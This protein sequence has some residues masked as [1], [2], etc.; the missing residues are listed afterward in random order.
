[1]MK[2]Q[3][4]GFGERDARF[5]TGLDPRPASITNAEASSADDPATDRRSAPSIGRRAAQAFRDVAEIV[6]GERWMRR[7]FPRYPKRPP[8]FFNELGQPHYHGHRER[9]RRRFLATWPDGLP[10]YELLELVLFNAVPRIDVKP[11]AKKLLEVFGSLNAVVAAPEQRLRMIAGVDDKV[12]VQLRLV[13]ALAGRMAQTEL[14]GRCVLSSWTAVLDYCRTTMAFRD[15]EQFRVLYL[16]NANHLIEDV[17]FAEGTVNHTPVYPREVVAR[18]LAVNAV[19]LILIHNHPSG[20][21]APSDA[22]IVM[23]RKIRDA[24]DAVSLRLLDHIIVGKGS[25]SSFQALGYLR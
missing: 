25:E 24:C 2:E 19:S 9:L 13:A 12:V 17:L 15:R 1:M 21:P 14:K 6:M 4:Q 5:E 8:N 7:W 23:T 3:D 10:D 11:L 20:N 16:D 22:D 18:G